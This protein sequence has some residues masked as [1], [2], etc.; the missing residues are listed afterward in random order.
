ML[1][2]HFFFFFG[3]FKLEQKKKKKRKKHL[4]LLH[5]KTA[6]T[7]IYWLQL[8]MVKFIPQYFWNIVKFETLENIEFP[9][10]TLFI[11]GIPSCEHLLQRWP[12]LI[13]LFFFS[14]FA[15]QRMKQR[16]IVN[17]DFVDWY[18]S[19]SKVCRPVKSI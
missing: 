11:R 6:K 16:I 4:M 12:S 10:Q 18:G 9:L 17:V 8:K 3:I 7:I 19:I 5:S 13:S 1:I 15:S 2:R 14:R